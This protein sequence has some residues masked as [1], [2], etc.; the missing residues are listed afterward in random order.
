M[1]IGQEPVNDLEAVPGIYKQLGR[2][3]ARSDTAIFCG[4]F[5]GPDSGGANSRD[6]VLLSLGLMDGFG[7]TWGNSKVFRQHLVLLYGFFPDRLKGG[8]THI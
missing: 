3:T 1:K 2:E 5:Q 7:C 8:Q 6:C 4:A